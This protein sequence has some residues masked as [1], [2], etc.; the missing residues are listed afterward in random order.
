M[1]ALALDK[2]F[3]VSRRADAT[4]DFRQSPTLSE[5]TAFISLA[6]R[7]VFTFAS[8]LSTGNHA[9]A[10]ERRH[11][12]ISCRHD[13][14]ALLRPLITRRATGHT[15]LAR[16]ERRRRLRHRRHFA[17]PDTHFTRGYFFQLMYT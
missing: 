9:A 8:A 13:A 11:M 6:T 16:S 14:A 1:I 10:A 5:S 7:G 3:P 2:R 4:F 17:S 12:L 15:A